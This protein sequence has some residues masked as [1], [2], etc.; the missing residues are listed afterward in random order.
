MPWEEPL[1]EE[2]LAA[3]EAGE[4]VAGGDPA[5]AGMPTGA[6]MDVSGGAEVED[7]G[8]SGPGW[9]VQVFGFHDHNFDV[10]DRTD[11]GAT[12]VHDTLIKNLHNFQIDLPNADRTGMESV[13]AEEFKI[14]Y[15]VLLDPQKVYPQTED[16]PYAKSG[17]GGESDMDAA[18]GTGGRLH[19]R[20]F[21][22][23][24][25]F[26]WI[27]KTP[28]EREAARETR[29]S[30]KAQQ[31]AEWD[32]QRDQ[33]YRDEHRKVEVALKQANYRVIVASK[34]LGMTPAGL[35]QKMVRLGFYTRKPIGEKKGGSHV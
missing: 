18:P 1:P 14:A 29:L 17:T 12:F 22:F 8:P 2:E 28:T 11:W 10:A 34:T 33:K 24:V 26:C 23:R 27:P 5:A 3:D 32:K 15:P 9:V 19:L 13:S 6:P 31:R 35:Y 21:D 20:R 4:G 25:Q 30:E 16:S 7:P